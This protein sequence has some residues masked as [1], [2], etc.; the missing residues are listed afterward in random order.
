MTPQTVE[1]PHCRSLQWHGTEV[2]EI[3]AQ[4]A[5]VR[6]SAFGGQL[7]SWQP[8]AGDEVLWL[9]RQLADL[10]VPL[11]GGVPLCWP[12]FGRQGQSPS[13]PSHG[14]ARTTRWQLAA[15][16]VLADGR[17]E[18][19]LRPAQRLHPQLEVFQ[20]VVI[21]RVLEQTLHTLNE[22][23]EAVSLTQALHSYFRVD[24]AADA[25]VHGLEGTAYADA[26]KPSV[27]GVQQGPWRFDA[28]RDG[29]RCD[30]IHITAG[31]ALL[32]DRG[33]A[34]AA[35]KIQPGGSNSL[36]LWT[37]GPALGQSMP[38]VGAGWADYLCLEVANAGADV[39]ELSPGQGH[40]L[41]QVLS[42]QS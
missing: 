33:P 1:A 19:V 35:L 3:H 4:G 28:S 41:K 7:L 17:L 8:L 29:G 21:G 11:R 42:L 37:P 5:R 12:W 36:V 30:R 38:D 24:V 13:A 18:V 34:R 40:A 27:P 6:I 23:S 2:W 22:G 25:V 15:Q 20:T 10:P 32:L 31:Q 16:Q 14:L 9:S 26:L 39:I